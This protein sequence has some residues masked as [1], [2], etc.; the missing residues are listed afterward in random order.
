MRNNHIQINL[1]EIPTINSADTTVANY[2]DI[3]DIIFK[4]VDNGL[5]LFLDATD[6]NSYSGS[7]DQWTSRNY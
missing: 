7:G 1:M 2:L 6:S 4:I 3:K 5:V